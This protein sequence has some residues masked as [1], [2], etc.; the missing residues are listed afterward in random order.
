MLFKKDSKQHKKKKK[1]KAASQL[2]QLSELLG[3]R[4][5]SQQYPLDDLLSNIKESCPESIDIG[6]LADMLQKEPFYLSHHFTDI[7]LQNLFEAEKLSSY[8]TINT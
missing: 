5:R 8:L 1:D 3:F 2:I 7:V 6:Q 4:L